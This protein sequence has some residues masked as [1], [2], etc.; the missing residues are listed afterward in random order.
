MDLAEGR[1]TVSLLFVWSK[2]KAQVYFAPKQTVLCA[3]PRAYFDRCVLV[4]QRRRSGVSGYRRRRSQRGVGC[5]HCDGTGREWNLTQYGRRRRQES[6]PNGPGEV[7]GLLL[8]P[9]DLLGEKNPAKAAR[10]GFFAGR[11]RDSITEA[12]PLTYLRLRRPKFAKL[13]LGPGVFRHVLEIDIRC[14]LRN[15]F[16][17]DAPGRRERV[18]SMLPR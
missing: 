18:R 16:C 11:G 7:P 1:Q 3:R 6:R 2:Y 10:N 13:S 12:G 5:V 15:A 14:L 8:R 17:S 4:S 9:T